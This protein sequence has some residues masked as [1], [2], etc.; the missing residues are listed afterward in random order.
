MS[1]NLVHS[2]RRQHRLPTQTVPQANGGGDFVPLALPHP[3]GVAGAGDIR[4][5]LPRAG[6]TVSVSWP[7]APGAECAAWLAQWLR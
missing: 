3:A 7:A 6:T 4:I 1:A 2:W 5:E